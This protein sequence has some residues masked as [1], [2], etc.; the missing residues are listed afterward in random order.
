MLT[1]HNIDNLLGGVSQQSPGSRFPNQCEEQVNASIRPI[2]GLTKRPPTEH[3]FE[4]QGQ[5]I[6]ASAYHIIDRDES[7]QYLVSAT[8]LGGNVSLNVYDING[9]GTPITVTAPG[10]YSYLQTQDPER[11]LRFVTFDDFTFILNKTVTTAMTADVTLG[12]LGYDS[13]HYLI[14]WL[15]AANY[16]T[17]LKILV[18]R[19]GEGSR[20]VTI[21]TGDGQTGGLAEVNTLNLMR[22][23]ENAFEV[24]A[25]NA[26]TSNATI[27]L[28]NGTGYNPNNWQF[29]REKNFLV[30]YRDDPR[31]DFYFR[32][33]DSSG[34]QLLNYAKDKVNT[35]TELPAVAV[36]D[37][38][39]EVQGSE[40]AKPYYVQFEAVENVN[41]GLGRGVWRECAKPGV[42]YKIDRT[43]MP[44]ALRRLSNG[45]FEF[46]PVG[47]AGTDAW[48]ERSVGDE[49]TNQDP[50]FIGSTLDAMCF[51]QSRLVMCSGESVV[52]SET[53]EPF[54]FWRTTVL[55]LPDTERIDIQAA[56]DDVN[57]I[58]WAVPA[59]ARL[60]ILSENAQFV[61]QGDV[62][63]TPTN[64]SMTMATEYSSHPYAKPQVLGSSV[65]LPT[66]GGSNGGL[67][68]LVDQ[69]SFKE[70]AF[71]APLL[72]API[73]TYIPGAPGFVAVSEQSGHVVISP[74]LSSFKSN[75][76][77]YNFWQNEGNRVQSAWH[78]WTMSGTGAARYGDFIGTRL[79]LVVQRGT[80]MFLEALETTGIE[81]VEPSRC[82]NYL[83]RR[84]QSNIPTVVTAYD[85]VA[86]ATTWTL[87][88][89][90]EIVPSWPTE[91]GSF[92][93]VMQYNIV[94]AEKRAG[95]RIPIDSITG[96]Q[97]V[98]EGNYQGVLVEFG[99]QY[100]T[101]YQFS[102]IYFMRDFGAGPRPITSGRLSMRYL[103]LLME[104]TGDLSVER[105]YRGTDFYIDEVL[106]GLGATDLFSGSRRIALFGENTETVVRLYNFSYK[107]CR[108]T[109]ATFESSWRPY[110]RG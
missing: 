55:D 102:P 100:A 77:V 92:Q 37:M 70:L 1:Q 83:D 26:T 19:S 13:G 52:M 8:S 105:V 95:V 88:Y 89:A 2:F 40:N 23:F 78:K 107:P 11:D 38:I 62:G 91:G 64:V 60:Y 85:P 74:L 12:L 109:G 69:S 46:A 14:V 110:T 96:N 73:P 79:Y 42:Q 63:I 54:N 76:Y 86:D 90:P 61:V 32:V 80:K 16:D 82:E 33:E 29:R 20:Q 18:Q 3:L 68:E 47:F 104:E 72:T 97:V 65:L 9:T 93:A 101:S 58:N 24:G 108:I 56:S 67:R 30:I 6:A 71:D 34:G 87:P 17:E 57:N 98:A 43:T 51:F 25:T 45:T 22:D 49:D 39:F 35:F 28:Q 106:G 94:D 27:T 50:T 31:Q 53:N 10:G 7:E 44:H 15:D 103:R 4:L 5:S 59:G 84:V 66:L 21:K 99:E 36:T 41:I 81:S 75:L 48:G